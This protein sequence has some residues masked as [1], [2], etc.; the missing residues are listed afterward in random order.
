MSRNTN[1]LLVPGA[2]Q[3]LEE[4]KNEIAKEMGITLGADT[5]SRLNGSVG[6]EMVK[7]LVAMAQQ[8][9]SQNN[10]MK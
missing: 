1:K 5:T 6:G 7:R 9:M 8:Q 4:M 2:G 3:A 10:K